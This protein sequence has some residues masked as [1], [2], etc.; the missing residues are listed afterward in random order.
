MSAS[1][2]NFVY[3]RLWGH[4]ND[5][6]QIT[7]QLLDRPLS[8]PHGGVLCIKCFRG[9]NQVHTSHLVAIHPLSR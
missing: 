7:Y 2:G 1:G 5:F 9:L 8:S 6:V 4:F 3:V